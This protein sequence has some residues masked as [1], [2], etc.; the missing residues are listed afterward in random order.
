MSDSTPLRI[1]MVGTPWHSMPPGGYGGIES[2]T[3]DLVDGLVD[4]GHDVTLIGV[5]PNGTKAQRMFPTYE[6]PQFA[7]MQ[8]RWPEITHV[9]YTQK[10]LADLQVDVV[11]DHSAAGPLLAAG[12]RVPTVVTAHGPLEGP[13][14]TD[15][16][17]IAR[18][19]RLMSG[20]ASFVA[21]SD[22]QRHL[23]PDMTWAGTV[24]NAV[25][26]EEFPFQERKEDFV[27]F[28]GKMYPYKGAHLAIE[29]A[30]A[31]GVRLVLAGRCVEE[32]E[33]AYW[34]AEIAPRMGDDVEWIGEL[35][36]DRKL[37][38]MKRAQA[39]LFPVIWPEPF[40]LVMTE[41]MACGTPVVAL[42]NGSVPEIVADGVSGI[43]C[44]DPSE[45]PDA[46]HAATALS[47]AACRRHVESHFDTATMARGY[48]A[49]YR[50]VIEECRQ[51]G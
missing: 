15:R 39:F 27:M 1:A 23:G 4:L 14:G 33:K 21:I 34:D 29:A 19:Y 8:E 5:G 6:S 22:A 26:V 46:I 25:R 18:F 50:T 16:D 31:A 49:V 51:L 37:D 24:H 10:I 12:R 36:T 40:G 30:R 20:Y 28:L 17:D 43:I 2:M 42:R 32:E 3:A 48:E 35:N 11:H 38:Y 45:L 7:R 47:P 9:A 41:A 44:D 13:I